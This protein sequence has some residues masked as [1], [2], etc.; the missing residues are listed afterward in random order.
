MKNA[1]PVSLTVRGTITLNQGDLDA[2]FELVEWVEKAA[3][4]P[5]LSSL[6]LTVE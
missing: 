3:A 2:W 6:H 5:R 4:D 1:V